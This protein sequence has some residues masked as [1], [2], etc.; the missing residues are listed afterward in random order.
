MVWTWLLNWNPGGQFAVVWLC[1]RFFQLTN[2]LV[3][4]FLCSGQWVNKSVD[5]CFEKG[6]SVLKFLS[7]LK[8]TFL[9]HCRFTLFQNNLRFWR[10]AGS[11]K[12]MCEKQVP[13]NSRCGHIIGFG[14]LRRAFLQTM[15]L[16]LWL[17]VNSSEVKQKILRL[18]VGS[19]F[20][21]CQGYHNDEAVYQLLT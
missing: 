11:N 14:C 19:L 2:T 15:Y 16:W 18:K 12:G 13:I 1:P 9:H 17:K 5:Y 7:S 4:L 10:S 21:K 8:M 20:R 6:D 3:I